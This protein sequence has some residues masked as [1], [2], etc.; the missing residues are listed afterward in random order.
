MRVAVADP[1]AEKSGA[2]SAARIKIRAV[3][4][5]DVAATVPLIK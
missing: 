5:Y 3:L 4:A 1:A 2:L